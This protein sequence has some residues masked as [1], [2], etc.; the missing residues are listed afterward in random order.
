LTRPS[1]LAL[2][3]HGNDR[4][5]GRVFY[6]AILN[7]HGL[8]HDPFKALVVPRPIGWVSTLSSK[9]IANLAPYSFFNAVSE[10]PHFV[11]FSSGGP[12]D[13]LRNVEETGEFVCSLATYALRHQVNLSSA[14]VPYGVDEFRLAGLTAAPSRLV[15]PPRVKESP[16]AFECRH[17]RTIALPGGDERA[18]YSVVFGQVVGIH[19]D[20]AFIKD[21]KVD[22]GALQPIARLGYREYG[23]ITSEAVFA[24]DRPRVDADG[25][26]IAANAAE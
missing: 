26:V 10:R 21:G 12:K 3:D 17:W 14:A 5:Q 9:G 19:I 8:K 6:D 22:T 1:E 15:K 23:V 13:S 24:I 25:N 18:S 2:E 4:E 11:M 16:V 20:D 7:D